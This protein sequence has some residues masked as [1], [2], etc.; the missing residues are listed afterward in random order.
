MITGHH[1]GN[2]GDD[3]FV[4]FTVRREQMTVKFNFDQERHGLSHDVDYPPEYLYRYGL[5]PSY[6][7]KTFTIFADIIYNHYR[8]VDFDNDPLTLDIRPGTRRDEYIAGLGIEI[9]L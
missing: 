7:F 1:V 2:D 3:L 4:E 8:N 9:P 5:M 6:R